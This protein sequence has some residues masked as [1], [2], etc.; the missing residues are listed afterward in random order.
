MLL[1]LMVIS[2]FAEV[3]SLGAVLPFIGILTAPERVFNHPVVA[4]L[5]QALG[6]ATAEQL[7][8]PLTVMFATAALIAGA[9]RIFLLW[10]TTRLAVVSGADLSIEVYRRTL[11][12]PYWVHAARNSSDTISGI[13]SKVNITVFGVLL[14]LLTLISSFVLLTAVMIALIVID[15]VIALV[16]IVGFGASYGLVTWLTRRRL[17]RNS[18]RI[19]FE[20][21]QVIKALQEGLGGIRDVLLDG[22]QPIYCDVYRQADHPLRQAHGNNIFIGGSP[23]FAM[24][25]LGMVLIAVLAYVLSRQVGG[26]ATAL[27]AL[28][29]LALGAQRLLPA[30]QQIYSAWASIA[31]S[32]ASLAG[33]IELLDQP[34]PADVLQPTT[35]PLRFQKD[36]RFNAVRFRYTHDGP[37]V[38]DGL[39]L[40]I[41]KG[42]RVGF[43]GSTGSGKS[44][45][46]DLLM[47]LLMPTQ[48]VL[49][50]DGHPIRGKRIRAWQR[51]IAHVPQ[52][53]FL[54]DTTLAEN[55][56]FGVPRGDID[57][58]RV[59]QVARQAQIAEFIESRPEGYNAYVGERGIRLSGGQRQRIGIARALYKQATVLVFD[60]ATSALDNATEQS[61]MDAIAALNRDLTVLLIAHR[62]TT[63]RRCD[64]IVELE[65]GRVVA[66]G[67]YD[68]LLERSPSFRS[69]AKA[70]E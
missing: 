64:S 29:A 32:R 54:A 57:M 51:S 52:N 27:P 5:A 39:N 2:A 43:V 11:Y 44:T 48:G 19:A 22:T 69:I 53:I 21:T 67:T 8:L 4:D 28:G 56:A 13:T 41:P 33:T 70:V 50:V 6:I 66:Q 47:G 1:G 9:I 37:W 3:V 61:V 14:P 35:A 36:I 46:L 16:A 38:L 23:R 7:V 12:Q 34:L 40:V 49:L 58:D 31:G 55:I 18:M 26:I 24:E 68:Q 20:Q 25:A 15:P 62:L 65:G 45:T 10:V 59:R 42:A 63:V 17:E 30:L 60:E